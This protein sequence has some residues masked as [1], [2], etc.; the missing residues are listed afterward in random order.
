MGART[1]P[2]AVLVDAEGHEAPAADSDGRSPFQRPLPTTADTVAPGVTIVAPVEASPFAVGT[3]VDVDVTAADDVRL[4]SI[5]VTFAGVTKACFA[6]P[7][8]VTFFAPRVT[9]PTA[10]TVLAVAKDVSGQSASASVEVVV[11]PAGPAGPAGEGSRGDGRRPRIA[12]VTPWLTP[13]PV[14]PLSTYVPWADAEDEDGIETIEFFL[15]DGTGEPCLV[16]RM[17]ADAWPPRRGCAIPA[18]AEGAELPFLARATDRS[19]ESAE[20][21][22]LLVIRDGLRVV[23]PAI[24]ATHGSRHKGD[25][26]YVEGPVEVDGELRVGELHLRAGA[27]LRPARSGGTP[28]AVRIHAEGNLVLDAGSLVDVS[29]TGVRPLSGLDVVPPDGEGEGAPHGGDAGAEA[30]IRRAYGSCFAP[31][32]P[33]ARGGIA[34]TLGGGLVFLSARELILAGVVTADGEDSGGD[35]P[36]W[37][38]LGAGGS[39]YLQALERITGPPDEGSRRRGILSARGGSP[40]PAEASPFPMAFAAGGRISL[41]APSVTL[42]ALDVAGTRLPDGTAS[43]RPGTVFLRDAARPDGVFVLPPAGGGSDGTAPGEAP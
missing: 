24:L 26:V 37:R 11:E 42:P 28:E 38:G 23:G 19:G 8:R 41:L 3:P 43:G 5:E 2:R 35:R 40:S 30:A 33:G 10:Q 9:G 36:A 13:S 12:F 20:A 31:V 21:R 6:S 14:P 25:L 22:A 1:N 7:C 39:I 18:L 15:G 17:P 16:L 29:A 34:G 27:T 4:R 32:L